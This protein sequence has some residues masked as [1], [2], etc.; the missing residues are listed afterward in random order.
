MRVYY[1]EFDLKAAAWLREL[2]RAGLMPDGDVDER[3]IR[4]VKADEIRGYDRVHLFC[5]IAGWELALQLAGWN[6]DRRV[7]TGSCPCFPAGTLVLT[8]G[9][10]KPIEDVQVG[11]KVLTHS[12]RFMPVTHTGTEMAECVKVKGQGHFGMVCTP[13]HPFYVSDGG[14]PYWCPASEL[15]GKR[16]ATVALVPPLP[17]PEYRV[18]KH[19]W[20][21]DRVSDRYR[22]FGEKNGKRV[23][24]GA[25]STPAEAEQARRT[26]VDSGVITVRGADAIDVNSL[27]FARFLGYWLGDGWVSRDTVFLCGAKEDCGLLNSLFAGAKLKGRAYIEKTSSRIRCGSKDLSSWLLEHFGRYAHGKKI[28]AWL[29][30]MP[31][32]YRTAFLRGYLLADGYRSRQPRGDG[33]TASITTVSRALA[34]GMRVLLNQSGY[35]VSIGKIANNREAV[36][37]GRRVNELPTYRV[38]AYESARSFRFSG[39]HGWGVVRSVEPAG[40]HRVYNLAVQ[41]D[42]SYTADGIVV[43]NCQPYSSAGKGKGQ[44]DDRHLWPEMFRLVREC[45]PPT[46]LGEQ[47]A[48]AI[49]FGWLDGVQA[50]LEG[51]GYACG[52]AVLG[53][54]SVNSPHKRQRLYWVAT[55]PGSGGGE[56]VPD[57]SG[58]RREQSTERPPREK[59]NPTGGGGLGTVPNA[60]GTTGQRHAGGLPETQARVSGTDW[61]QHGDCPVGLEHGGSTGT[62]PDTGQLPSRIASSGEGVEEDGWKGKGQMVDQSGQ[63]GGCGFWGDYEILHFLDGKARRIEPG[64]FP[65]VAGF[66]GR[67]DLLRGYGNSIVPQCAAEFIRAFL[68][69]ESDLNP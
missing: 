9:G 65:L 33:K 35:S 21:F 34:I 39:Q 48:A 47:V 53:A 10:Y 64:T 6:P 58:N 31:S 60:S 54:H 42:E 7:W 46:V 22:A 19:G 25:Y 24:L 30:S 57:G 36:I 38:T 20:V 50:D 67:V 44:E 13:N 17:I 26:A 1:N 8:E 23:H 66:P 55:L 12:T 11:D 18:G 51:E 37:G 45:R 63:C 32:D 69:A 28:P 27:G 3:D 5:G 40:V 14:D 52:A 16:W 61:K 49:G 43:H 68:E 59:S 15:K 2:I 41:D 56:S 62:V 4:E 29:H